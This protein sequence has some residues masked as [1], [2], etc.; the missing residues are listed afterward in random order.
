MDRYFIDLMLEQICKGSMV[1]QKFSKQAWADILQKFNAN[2]GFQHHKDDLESHFKIL[3]NTF[4]DMKSLL[5]Q[6]G[7]EWDELHQM[8]TANDDLWDAF[9][10][11]HISIFM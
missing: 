11:V 7:F 1:N 8:I 5:D 9:V 10:A 3:R 2:F 6:N 4:N